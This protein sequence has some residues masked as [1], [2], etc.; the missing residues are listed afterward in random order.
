M[1][2]TDVAIIG[3]GPAGSFLATHLALNGV[4][5]EVFERETFPRFH[6]GQSL[7][8]MSIPLLEEIDVDLASVDYS[9]RKEG[10]L[11]YSTEMDELRRFDF[12]NTMDGTF[13]YAYQVERGPFDKHLADRASEAGARIRYNHTVKDWTERD[14]S[15]VIEG[16]EDT[17]TA[18]YMVDATGQRAMMAH[19]QN[20][21]ERIEEFGQ[22]ASFGLFRDVTNDR[23]QDLFQHGDVLVLTFGDAWGWCIRLPDDK[24]SVGLV[25]RDPVTGRAAE[26]VIENLQSN[27]P[28][29]DD[30]LEGARPPEQYHRSANYSFVN[31]CPVTDRVVAVGDAYTFLDP[32]YASA[33]H[34]A[35]YS[36]RLLSKELV[37]HL[38]TNRDLQLT[39]YFHEVNRACKV[40]TRMI[41]KF[42]N[43]NWI[44]NMFF[45]ENQ[46]LKTQREITSILCGDIWRDD[47]QYQNMMLNASRGAYFSDH[48]SSENTA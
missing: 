8:P 47:N 13:T 20:A 24:A 11:F 34:R 21:F 35:F 23:F 12:D 33:I 42:Y 15:V 41:E 40:F 6:V 29:F 30:L 38:E 22:T 2:D 48:A 7:V 28:F 18:K 43:T 39:S 14:D 37:E 32:I 45:G 25:E 1:T 9:V 17:S 10:A 31:N 26:T 16:N 5:V 3:A 19:K 36:A 46:P 4:S 27:C 44:E